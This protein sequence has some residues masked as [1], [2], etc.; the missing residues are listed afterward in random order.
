MT[1]TVIM[2]VG[3]HVPERVVTNEELTK[4]MET[5][6][7]WIVERTGIHERRWVTEGTSGAQMAEQA[8]LEAVEKAGIELQDIDCIVLATLSP[9]HTFPG[10][11]CFLQHR[12]GL[13][14]VPALDVRAQCSGF[15][16]GLSVA[17]A[18][19]RIGQ[20]RR[21]LMVG[22]EVHSTGLDLSTRGRDVACLFGDGAGAVVLGASDDDRGIL[23]IKLHADGKYAKSLWIEAPGSCLTPR[24]DEEMI[25]EARHYP[26][27]KGRHVFTFAL[28]KMPE[29]IHEAL[30]SSGFS[31]SDVDLIIP[32]QANKR[33]TEQVAKQLG[34]S[35]E[36]MF[37]N[38]EKLGN[39][40]A[41]S[42]PLAIYDA[43][44]QGRLKTGDLVVFASFGAGFTWAAAVCRW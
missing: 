11:G 22:T 14:G 29:V 18:W 33:I 20:Y 41:A 13:Q 42:I 43:Q 39:T 2:G 44:R 1:K 3:H 32:H 19:I 40:T 34:V 26:K 27:M 38:I 15:I 28:Q 7:Q 5:S 23:S 36:L 16:Y 30:E 21:I 37:S 31:L 35:D 10:T 25:R 12:L 24:I 17:D 6:D 4:W 9:D 8:A